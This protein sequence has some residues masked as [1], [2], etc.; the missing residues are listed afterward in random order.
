MTD[1]N[2]AERETTAAPELQAKLVTLPEGDDALSRL[3]PDAADT[4]CRRLAR[5]HLALRAE[6]ALP[7]CAEAPVCAA[8]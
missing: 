7:T 5:R 2:F 3:R 1:C 4:C 8:L 6:A